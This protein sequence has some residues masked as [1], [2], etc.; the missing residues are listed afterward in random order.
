VAISNLAFDRGTIDMNIENREKYAYPLGWPV[1]KRNMLDRIYADNLPISRR[2][3]KVLSLRYLAFGISE[4]IQGK[5]R[6]KIKEAAQPA[7]NRR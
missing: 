1:N 7:A 2:N 3:D 5:S 4:K 6:S